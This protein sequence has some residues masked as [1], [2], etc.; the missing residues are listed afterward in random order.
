[1]ALALDL[2]KGLSFRVKARV[3]LIT[4]LS[5]DDEHSNQ[6]GKILICLCSDGCNIKRRT[7]KKKRKDRNPPEIEHSSL[8]KDNQD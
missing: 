3:N 8:D 4:F 6:Q 5:V 7:D 2:R 1:L